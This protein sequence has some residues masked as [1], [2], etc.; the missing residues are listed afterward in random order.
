MSQNTPIT[1]NIPL[2]GGPY[3]GGFAAYS[4]LVVGDH[5]APSQTWAWVR[6]GHMYMLGPDNKEFVYVGPFKAEVSVE[7]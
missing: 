2:R 7:P 3:D 6:E 4:S 1:Q 5:T